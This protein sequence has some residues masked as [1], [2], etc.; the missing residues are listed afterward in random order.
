M[1]YTGE[2]S[3]DDSEYNTNLIER[4]DQLQQDGLILF[5]K[6]KYEE[7]KSRLEESICAYNEAIN[8]ETDPGKRAE[9]H[10]NISRVRDKFSEIDVILSIKSKIEACKIYISQGNYIKSRRVLDPI[11]EK[12]PHNPNALG[13]KA[14]SYY[15]EGSYLQALEFIDYAVESDRE[16]STLWFYKGKILLKLTKPRDALEAF[17]QS[18][19]LNDEY[20]EAWKLI[21]AINYDLGDY[22]KTIS[23][24]EKA[25]VT[26]SDLKTFKLWIYALL[27]DDRP[28]DARK[29]IREA[30]DQSPLDMADEELNYL[31]A[32]SCVY[33]GEYQDA[34]RALTNILEKNPFHINARYFCAYSMLFANQNSDDKQ[35]YEEAMNE[36]NSLLDQDPLHQNGLYLKG[37]LLTLQNSNQE[38]IAIY[39]D[40]AKKNPKY[41][42]V[43]ISKASTLVQEKKYLEAIEIVK[44]V[45]YLDPKHEGAQFILGGSYRE[46]GD[47]FNARDK[48]DQLILQNP[49][50]YN[51]LCLNGKILLD[52]EEYDTAINE[53]LKVLNLEITVSSD[54]I[55][56][57]KYQLATAYYKRKL[58]SDAINYFVQY[59]SGSNKN[60]EEVYSNISVCYN[61]IGQYDLAIESADSAISLDKTG[62]LAYL[63]RA[64]ALISLD[65][66]EDAITAY[67]CLTKLKPED[68][69]EWNSYGVL[70][71]R[72]GRK[73]DA[74]HAF[75]KA[76]EIDD[77]EGVYLYNT[78]IVNTDSGNTSE[79]LKDIERAIAQCSNNSEYWYLKAIIL[80]N[81][82]LYP[83][84]MI[85]VTMAL[86]YKHDYSDALELKAQLFPRMDDD[87][88]QKKDIIKERLNRKIQSD[89]KIP[90]PIENEFEEE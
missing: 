55:S 86:Q 38:A 5:E 76:L 48:L 11:L 4:G 80:S 18:V 9:F 69:D 6:K 15:H 58:W 21:A 33:E 87:I 24:F 22:R 57:S 56:D 74:L 12:Y 51:A 3:G 50:N 79:A 63:Q 82:R 71:Y 35:I 23:A 68:P 26:P 16:N 54:I 67:D 14:R 41:L 83:E 88:N 52:L 44:Q 10:E 89:S 70:L 61:K 7:S 77:S 72:V 62:K 81:N 29:K 53:F 64:N 73:K 78:A 1:V 28:D 45:L 46:I 90:D 85:A 43:F 25:N 37:I 30:L 27:K 65:K 40:I 13:C 32:E 59:L 47:W 17:Q 84:A 49:N 36:V 20:C 31:W 75:R 2:S 34:I 60:S 8:V 19:A 39:D 42:N 66:L